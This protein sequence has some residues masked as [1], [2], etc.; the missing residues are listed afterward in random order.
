[1][2]RIENKPMPGI[3]FRAMSL[4]FK[5]RDILSDP[6]DKL[7]KAGIDDGQTV[8]DYGCGPGSYTIPAARMVGEQGKVY[9]IDIHPLAVE[10]VESKAARANLK[11]IVT[12][13][14]ERNTGLPDECVDTALLFDAIH[15][16]EDK[17]ALLG[18]LHRVI[19]PNGRLSIFVEH[20]KPDSVIRIAEMDGLFSLKDRHGK[21]FNFERQA[22]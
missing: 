11:N 21:L 6:V 2:R 8:L 10:A 17:K 7:R 5:I 4:C 20:T 1:M 22:G 16:I 9:A 19:R 13:L 3:G 15:M 14:S 12:I 18:E